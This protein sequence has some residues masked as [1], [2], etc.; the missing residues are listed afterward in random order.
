MVY[1][2]N[3][4]EGRASYGDYQKYY[5]YYW[6]VV[7][8]VREFKINEQWTLCLDAIRE[9]HQLIPP[10]HDKLKHWNKRYKKRLEEAYEALNQLENDKNQYLNMEITNRMPSKITNITEILHKMG[11]IQDLYVRRRKEIEEFDDEDFQDGSDI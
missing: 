9:W 2:E 6:L 11:H 4:Y 10:N 5:K 1:E 7:Q 3:T 8:Q